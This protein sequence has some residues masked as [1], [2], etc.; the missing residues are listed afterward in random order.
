M[1]SII[2]QDFADLLVL[3]LCRGSLI[4]E[5]KAQVAQLLQEHQLVVELMQSR[6][7]SGTF[8]S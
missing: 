4:N 8:S 1:V 7:G 3:K 2:I 6:L 5:L